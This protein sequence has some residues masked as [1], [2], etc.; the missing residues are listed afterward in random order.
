[1]ILPAPTTPPGFRMAT[2]VHDDQG[3]PLP[4]EPLSPTDIGRLQ[5]V[6]SDFQSRNPTL[7]AALKSEDILLTRGRLQQGLHLD[8]AGINVVTPASTPKT[9]SQYLWWVWDWAGADYQQGTEP[10]EQARIDGSDALETLCSQPDKD[11]MTK[12]NETRYRNAYSTVIVLDFDR[13]EAHNADPVETLQHELGHALNFQTVTAGKDPTK[14][15]SPPLSADLIKKL[16]GFDMGHITTQQGLLSE[17]AAES[18]EGSQTFDPGKFSEEFDLLFGVDGYRDV[19]GN[20][21]TPAGYGVRIAKDL[22]LLDAKSRY[23]SFDLAG[24][25]PLFLR[26]EVSIPKEKRSFVLLTGQ[27]GTK[28]DAKNAAATLIGAHAN[29]DGKVESY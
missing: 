17:F 20:T 21:A 19:D 18:L 5:V 9:Q 27:Y 16:K 7:H 8:N 15:T 11:L 13:I 29:L 10:N 2:L 25:T 14:D 24:V 26:T 6:M 12:T 28:N 4:A 22:T 23:R 1:M 3:N